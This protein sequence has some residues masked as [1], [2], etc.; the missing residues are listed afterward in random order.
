MS[1]TVRLLDSQRDGIVALRREAYRIADEIDSGY[2]EIGAEVGSSTNTERA[3]LVR[4]GVPFTGRAEL[5]DLDG[6]VLAG[7]RWY[8]MTGDARAWRL[9][10]DA[11]A[12]RR[13][14]QETNA[15]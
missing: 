4:L 14:I 11:R 1:E 15:A 10:D 8:S 13:W 2:E 6:L 7:E 3:E 9:A 5:E 12:L